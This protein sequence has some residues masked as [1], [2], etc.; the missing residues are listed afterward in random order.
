MKAKIKIEKEVEI[1]TIHVKA[2]V[3]YWEDSE[4]NGVPDDE[5]DLMPCRDGD[6]WCPVINIDTGIINGWPEGTTAD[7]HYKV[8]DQC[9]WSLHDENGDE[10]YSVE[11]EYVPGSLCPKE[12]GYGDY[13]IM[14]IDANGQIA[15][16][17]PNI[18][19]LFYE[20]D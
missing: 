18:D 16:W 14:D 6:L 15:D 17:R 12:E 11:N 2:N 4:I 9:S 8:V 13:I 10:I 5:G 19:N 20:E 7:V 3:R 1:K